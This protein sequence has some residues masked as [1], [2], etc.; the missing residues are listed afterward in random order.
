MQSILGTLIVLCFLTSDNDPEIDSGF[1]SGYLILFPFIITI[2]FG[3]LITSIYGYAKSN[4][5]ENP[6]T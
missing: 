1:I 4:H 6:L 5:H 2:Q 3:E